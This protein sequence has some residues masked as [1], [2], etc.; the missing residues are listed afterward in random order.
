MPNVPT[1]K[2]PKEFTGIPKG[3]PEKISRDEVEKRFKSL[4]GDFETPSCPLNLRVTDETELS[5][6]VIRQR[7]EYNV[8]PGETVSAIH[9]FKREAYRRM[10]PEFF[11]FMGMGGMIFSR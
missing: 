11:P 7:V 4:L 9:L 1:T 5:E 6:G 2:I 3:Y 10:R 8:E